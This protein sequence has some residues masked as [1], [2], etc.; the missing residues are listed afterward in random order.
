MN[1]N[2]NPHLCILTDSVDFIRHIA[3][4]T[5]VAQAG[6]TPSYS[7]MAF[8]LLGYIVERQAGKPFSEI[9]RQQVLTPLNM[10]E[11]TIFAPSNSSKGIIPVS[12]EASGWST[13][14]ASNEG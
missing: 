10:T 13:Y 5:P 11:T 1:S 7:N 14:H 9:L 12:K 4:Q 8:Q 2:P 6:V 3:D